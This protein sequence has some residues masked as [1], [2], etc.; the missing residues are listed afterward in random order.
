ME[1]HSEWNAIPRRNA[2]KGRLKGREVLKGVGARGDD[3]ALVLNW[4]VL[5]QSCEGLRPSR[6][7][8]PT[9]S[10][11]KGFGRFQ[12]GAGCQG[13]LQPTPSE[14]SLRFF[15]FNQ[16][17]GGVCSVKP[18]HPMVLGPAGGDLFRLTN[19]SEAFGPVC[20]V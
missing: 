14:D 15:S 1:S 8:W 4:V 13:A 9:P 11:S 19:P 7:L 3:P 17:L 12:K 10:L 18:T 5:G 2:Q 6:P 20:S 16:H